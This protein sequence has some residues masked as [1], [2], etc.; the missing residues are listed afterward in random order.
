[1]NARALVLAAILFSQATGQADGPAPAPGA[2]G[3]DGT[4]S[5][6][7]EA[8]CEHRCRTRA[9][10]FDDDRCRVYRERAADHGTP[11]AER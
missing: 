11:G 10:C 9:G 6:E 4:L 8:Y 5:P 1:M 7:D 3:T 2:P